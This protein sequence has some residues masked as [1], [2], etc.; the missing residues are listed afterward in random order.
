M[1]FFEI[2]AFPRESNARAGLRKVYRE[3][4]ISG[5]DFPSAFGRCERFEDKRNRNTAWNFFD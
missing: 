1:K 2:G 5:D 3:P 4:N